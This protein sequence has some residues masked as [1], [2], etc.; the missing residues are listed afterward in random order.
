[1]NTHVRDNFN[2]T[3]PA[4]VTA[5][6][7]LVAGTGA[8]TIARVPVGTD[9][10]PLIANSAC[11]AGVSYSDAVQIFAGA[12]RLMA[13]SLSSGNYFQFREY[14]T[15]PY[16]TSTLIVGASVGKNAYLNFIEFPTAGRWMV[17]IESGNSELQFASGTPGAS[18][19]KMMLSNVGHLYLN[20]GGSVARWPTVSG[21]EVLINHEFPALSL[22]RQ[23][24]SMPT[25][26]G[27]YINVVEDTFGEFL[28]INGAGGLSIA[29]TSSCQTSLRL[30]SLTASSNTTKSVQAVG[31]VSVE[32][33]YYIF[34][35]LENYYQAYPSF[36][37]NTNLFVIRAGTRNDSS[38]S[39]Q[40]IFDVEGD[41]HS[42]AAVSASAYDLW[43]DSH[44][45]RALMTEIGGRNI[46]R[47]EF[48]S[49]VQ[50]N[51]SHLEDLGIAS[52][53]DGGVFV[54]WTQFSRVLAGAAWQTAACL[55]RLERDY[56]EKIAALES[57]IDTLISGP[58]ATQIAG[59]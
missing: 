40:F 34:N 21:L 44:L 31:A 1:M 27:T 6:G 33:N 50:Y 58:T 45:A 13:I 35:P 24:L 42:N 15:D 11:N 39:T 55:M 22:R 7:D 49:W 46:V 57:R 5:K 3:A 29:G 20:P 28:T 19:L 43:D 14:P 38:A 59:A 23:A 32:S 16:L 2:E 8:N 47:T 25:G 41:M 30:Y 9:G 51:R 26:A 36:P 48:D 52:F 12:S 56:G 53:E 4:K 54:N 18:Q 17:G 37:A 10:R